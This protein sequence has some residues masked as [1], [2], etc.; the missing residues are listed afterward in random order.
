M[1]Q[2]W[3]HQHQCEDDHSQGVIRSVV[4]V[5]SLD[6]VGQDLH[7]PA[8]G[9]QTDGYQGPR[10]ALG[11]WSGPNDPGD[12]WNDDHHIVE[13]MGLALEDAAYRH[14][15]LISSTP[16]TRTGL[17]HCRALIPEPAL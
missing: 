9:H 6:Q 10:E 1:Y 7:Q 3:H 15:R 2:P 5:I 11:T 16:T 17:G 4:S 13:R 14:Q 8:T 12:G